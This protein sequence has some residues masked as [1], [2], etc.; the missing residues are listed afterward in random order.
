MPARTLMLIFTCLMVNVLSVS[1]Q[2]K[3]AYKFGKVNPA[4]FSIPVPAF[5][6]GAHAIIIG[7]VGSSVIA[8]NNKGGF[9]YEF[10]RK[11][12]MKIVDI[13][14]IDAGKFEIPLY[15]SKTST[16]REELISL[17]AVTYNLEGGKVL[18][19]KLENNQV[20]T[21]KQ[22]D[23]FQQ[24]K[25]SLPALKAGS[26][27]EISYIISSDFIFDFRPWEFQHDY[28]C[29][30]SDYEVEI[31]EYYDYVFL[32]QGY[33]PFHI[34]KSS[35]NA[36]TFMIRNNRSA[37]SSI[38]KAFSLDGFVT[39][40]RWVMKDVPSIKEENFTTTIENHRSKIEFQLSSIKYPQQPVEMV[41][42]SWPKVTTDFMKSEDFGSLLNRE[43]NWLDDVIEP[44]VRGESSPLAKAVKIFNYVRD[45]FTCTQH[46]GKYL[47]TGLK[48]MLK[49]KSGNVADMN[50]LLIAMLKH[51]KIECYP[52]ILSTRGHG[53]TNPVY[54]IVDRF[55]Y[56]ICNAVIGSQDYLLDATIPDLAFGRLSTECYNGHAR[57]LTDDAIPI[58]LSADSVMEKS[59]SMAIVVA[60][61]NQLKGKVTLSPGYFESL[62]KREFIRE[63][64]KPALFEKIQT[65]YGS[66]YVIS[67]TGIDSLKK[68]NDPIKIFYDIAL[69]EADEDIIYF[70][71]MLV[72][73]YKDNPFES[74]IRRYPVEIPYCI[75]DTYILNMQLPE[76]YL[77]DEL[78]KSARVK[79]NGDEGSF[80]YIVSVNEG[81]L[82][83]RTRLILAKAN[84]PAEDY[85][86]LRDFFSYVVKKQAEQIVLKKKSN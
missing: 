18:E 28:P 76:G 2:D 81:T 55:N 63:K 58:M 5:D 53:I 37:E 36:R 3:P 80:E 73:M 29:L 64:G 84:F 42:E 40:R 27:F 17:K 78:P 13:N 15:G 35:Q 21:E 86:G 56:V 47:S 74:A 72:P 68:L 57:V 22:S 65:N 24:K 61:K 69:K 6:S 67:N 12:R 54:P 77:V 8:P 46:N 32:T 16:S 26:I 20:F 38:D 41:M 75:D 11:L 30:W 34:V 23:A 66:D 70:N 39:Q 7:D 44:V 52:V 14:G 49:K 10:Q 50:L 33:Q 85:E 60:E 19:T 43:N 82:Q 45:N 62:D 59:V 83:L 31:P 71:P 25:F 51:E 1:A 79:F 48:S 9:G 4:D